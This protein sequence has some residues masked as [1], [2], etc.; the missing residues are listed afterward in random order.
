MLLPWRK[1]HFS[2]VRGLGRTKNR[3]L[4]A[5]DGCFLFRDSFLSKEKDTLINI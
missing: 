5:A 3:D 4:L 1:R 2:P